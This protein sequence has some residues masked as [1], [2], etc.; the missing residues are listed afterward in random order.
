MTV[1]RAEG[2]E[3]D[4]EK[5]AS[6]CHFT[7]DRGCANFG[8]EI[9]MITRSWA[10]ATRLFACVTLLLAVVAGRG[11]VVSVA[12]YHNDNSRTGQN[13]HESIL[14]PS[15][16]AESTFGKLFSCSVDGEVYAEPLYLPN[17]VIPTLG[18]HNVAYVATE[19]DSVYAFDADSNQGRNAT[20]LWHTSFID[21]AKGITTV[22]SSDLGTNAIVPEIGITGTPVID[23]SG[24]TLYVSAATK[25]NGVYVQRL[26]ALDVTTGAEKF[27]GP[28]II[29][30]SVSGSGTGSSGGTISFDPFRSNQRPAL[31]LSNGVVYLAWASH[32]LENEFPYHGWVIGYNETTLARVAAFNLT[33]DGDQGGVWQS[34]GGLAADALGSIFFM[35]GNG[36]FDANTGGSD[37]GMSYLRLIPK[38]G[39]SVAD[40]FT[41]YNEARLSGSDTDL[42]SGGA[43]LLPYQSGAAHPYLAIGAG[44][45]GV[46]YLVDR[47][48]MG[49]FNSSGNSQIVQSIVN[50]FDGRGLYA[51]PVYWQDQLYFWADGDVLRIFAMSGGLLG[52]RPIATSTVTFASG[53]TPVVSADGAADAIAWAIQSDQF[54]TGGPAV[55]Y[56]FD[57]GTAVE[58]YNS[59]QAGTRDTAGPA[60]KFTVPTV[61]NGKVYV[62]TATQLDVYGL[63]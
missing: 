41:P 40:Y 10:L 43:L 33:P 60:V 29:A 24:G 23:T 42:G 32:G 34:G 49:H 22:P 2:S 61:V 19:H 44:K 14:K 15:V 58:L 51:T 9:L 6:P 48:N 56:A 37:Y 21:P 31:L 3:S 57:G 53:S 8:I 11:Q 54:A 47:T 20:P 36:T 45:N 12:T 27:G 18:V 5:F 38:N 7:F 63:L 46:I 50:A 25:E 59:R 26:H 62:G 39:L 1:A 52:T 55:L 4:A 16:V 35:S 30:A 13:V 28:V 17:I